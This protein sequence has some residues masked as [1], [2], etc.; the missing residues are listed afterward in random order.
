MKQLKIF[1]VLVIIICFNAIFYIFHGT[2]NKTAVWIIYGFMNMSII[3]T[4]I[5]A[6][7]NYNKSDIKMS[8]IIIGVIYCIAEMV[9]GTILLLIA[10]D[11]S[12]WVVLLQLVIFCIALGG[13]LSYLIMDRR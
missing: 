11:S 1:L 10:P 6:S 2:D 5:I 13:N 12:L 7:L 4:T 3:Y 8:S 9:V